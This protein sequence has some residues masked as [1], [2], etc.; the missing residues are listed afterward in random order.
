[1][2][3]ACEECNKSLGCF[4]G[5]KACHKCE[6]ILCSKCAGLRPLIPFDNSKPNEEA[7]DLSKNGKVYSYCKTCFEETSVL[8][9]SKTYDIVNPTTSTASGDAVMTLIMVHG[10][11]ASRALYRPYAELLAAKGYSSILVDLPGHGSLV[12]QVLS[13]DE[14]V[15]VVTN[16]LY[17]NKLSKEQTVYVGGS[18]GAYIGFYVLEKLKDRFCGAVLMDCG[19]NVGPHCSIKASLGI[20]FLRMATKSLSNKGLMGAMVGVTK[21]SPANWKLV[22]SAF[23]AGNFFDQGHEQIECMHT[24]DPSIHIPSYDF[25]VLFFNGSEDHRDSEDWWLSLC[26]DQERSSLKVFEGGDHFFSHDTR[27]YGDVIERMDTFVALLA[28]RDE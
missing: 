28:P 23:G 22:E 4:S 13:L 26:K 14:C 17:E 9:F 7:N 24:V 15:K 21:K 16:I 8:D 27:F 19:Q 25:P 11:G 1:M 12:E 5:A 2:T 18:L 6:K 3:G 10:G 20:W